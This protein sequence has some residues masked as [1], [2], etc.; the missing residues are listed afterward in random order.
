LLV[1]WTGISDVDTTWEQLEDFKHQFPNVELADEL[2]VGR[3]GGD[4]VE[5]LWAS[6]IS[7]VYKSGR[8]RESVARIKEGFL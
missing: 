5:A 1:K 4:V 7:G 2:F 6:S 3:G 8:N